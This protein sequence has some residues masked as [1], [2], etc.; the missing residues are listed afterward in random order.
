M[1]QEFEGD[2][3]G[4][5]G[6]GSYS[7][8]QSSVSWNFSHLTD[9]QGIGSTSKL[10]QGTELARFSSLWAAG[11]RFYFS[12]RWPSVLCHMSLSVGQLRTGQLASSERVSERARGNASMRESASEIEFIPFDNP[13][14]DMTAHHFCHFLFLRSKSL[15]PAYKQGEGI[16]Q[17]SECKEVGVI[18]SHFRN[19]LPHLS[20]FSM[21][22]LIYEKYTAY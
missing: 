4:S 15:A 6:S 14:L 7:R 17:G 13:I 8:T 10:T 18:G 2:L 20:S 16:T 1:C 11:L 5:L 12:V 22:I 9:K 3:A 21:K 19:S